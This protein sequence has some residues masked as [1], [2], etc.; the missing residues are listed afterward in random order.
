MSNNIV[1]HI[2]CPECNARGQVEWVRFR[3]VLETRQLVEMND[4][5]DILET[6]PVDEADAE[7]AEDDVYRCAAC[8]YDFGNYSD[9][10]LKFVRED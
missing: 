8:G 3:L 6:R 9:D 1:P 10:L 4:C 2:V 7:P 5:G